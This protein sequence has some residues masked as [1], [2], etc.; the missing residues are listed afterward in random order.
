M[1][2]YQLQHNGEQLDTAI[3]L[4]LDNGTVTEN[5]PTS[6]EGLMKGS[7]GKVAAAVAGEDYVTPSQLATD[8]FKL[9]YPVGSIYLSVNSANPSSVFP[10]TTW[11]AWGAGRMPVGVSGGDADFGGAEK[12]GGAKS[13]ALN[14]SQVPPS[15]V[16]TFLDIYDAFV[17]AMTEQTTSNY[18]TVAYLKDRSQGAVTGTVQGQAQAHN[19]LPPYITC[20]MWKRTA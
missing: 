17:P 14:S 9:I 16:N 2:E 15:T 3:Q 12:T 20:Y 19:N 11:V 8:V 1:D 7:G 6:I 10:G 13:V 4:M 5:T 18:G